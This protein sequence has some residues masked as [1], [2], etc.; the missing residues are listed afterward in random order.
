MRKTLC[1]PIVHTSKIRIANWELIF[2]QAHIMR[3]LSV[4]FMCYVA[5]FSPRRSATCPGGS[6]KPRQLS[7]R[8]RRRRPLRKLSTIS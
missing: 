7:S 4:Q 3:T 6:E 1:I 5:D 8:S 2:P